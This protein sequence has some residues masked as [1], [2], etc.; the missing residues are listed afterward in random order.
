[1]KCKDCKLICAVGSEPQ[2]VAMDKA[3]KALFLR[4][5]KVGRPPENP[6]S[7]LRGYAEGLRE[8]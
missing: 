8:V 5:Q 3:C 2:N 4:C 1:M 7:W 6:M